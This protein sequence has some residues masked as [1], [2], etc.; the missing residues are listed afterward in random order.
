MFYVHYLLKL[1]L[2][3]QVMQVSLFL[4]V[5]NKYRNSCIYI[6]FDCA[7]GM[8]RDTKASWMIINNIR[9]KHNDFRC[10][11]GLVGLGTA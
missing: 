5:L 7:Y 3:G 11:A 1:Y 9:V 6:V 10:R 4:K 8:I 2:C